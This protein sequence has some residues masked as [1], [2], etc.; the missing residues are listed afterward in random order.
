[1]L[2]NKFKNK[3]FSIDL[4]LLLII[5]FLGYNWRKFMWSH[6]VLQTFSHVL[7]NLNT[8]ELVNAA[9][10]WRTPLK[11]WRHRQISATAAHFSMIATL[12]GISGTLIISEATNR[13]ISLKWRVIRRIWNAFVV[14]Q[15]R[16]TIQWF[17]GFWV[18]FQRNFWIPYSPSSR[19][20]LRTPR[21]GYQQIFYGLNMSSLLLFLKQRG[22]R[23]YL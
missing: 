4:F 13:E 20:G 15:T 5:E 16:I 9:H 2:R 22:F 6:T 7:F 11:L 1:M 3:T 8:D 10:I 18:T 23:Y 21:S 14:C 17:S 19:P 12:L